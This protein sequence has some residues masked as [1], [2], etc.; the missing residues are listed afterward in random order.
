MKQSKFEKNLVSV[1]MPVY[2]DKYLYDAI[3]S[4]LKQTYKNI[5]L[6]IVDDKSPYNIKGIVSSFKDDRLFYYRNKDNLGRNDPVANWN[7]CLEFVHGEFFC[8]LCDDDVYNEYFIEEMVSL[9]NKNSNCNV[10]RCKAG[11]I[12]NKGELKDMYPSSP[13]WESSEDYAL[14]LIR[15]LRF[16]TVSEFLYRTKYVLQKGG[17]VAFPKACYADW[18]S[19][20]YFSKENGICST[21]RILSFFRDSGENLSSV[22][23]D[24]VEKIHA[25]NMFC[26][27]IFSLYNDVDNIYI[28]LLKKDIRFFVKK[29]KSEYIGIS[30]WQ[31]ILF[32]FLKKKKKEFDIPL[33]CFVKGVQLKMFSIIKR[34]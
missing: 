14:H 6:I 23:S 9:A 1:L 19:V 11:I 29:R 28:E 34:S 18:F 27:K 21:N 26:Q 15:N 32:L 16:Q 4:V 10:F 25:L 31:K 24:T 20:L 12:S 3:D 17:Y 33:Y 30:S 22:T 7:K 8:L 13:I 2:K 5:E